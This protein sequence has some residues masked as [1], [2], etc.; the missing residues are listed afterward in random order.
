MSA[1][2]VGL[3]VVILIEGL[4]TA[5]NGLTK[6]ISQVIPIHVEHILWQVYLEML[7]THPLKVIYIPTD[8]ILIVEGVLRNVGYIFGEGVYLDTHSVKG[9]YL[10]ISCGRCS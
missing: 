6:I 3:L 9:I 2:K 8:H 5:W 4:R 10:Q 7:D 1:R